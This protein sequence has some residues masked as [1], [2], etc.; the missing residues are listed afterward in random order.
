MPQPQ[1]CQIWA[2]S[3]TCTTAHSSS[4]S[5]THWARQEIKP[6]SSGILVRFISAELQWELR[7]SV[8]QIS[9]F[10]SYRFLYFHFTNE[11]TKVW[12]SW[13]LYPRPYNL[14]R[15]HLGSEP[16]WSVST[17]S[18]SYPLLSAVTQ[19]CVQH[20]LWWG[21]SATDSWEW[22]TSVGKV[23][24]CGSIDQCESVR[25]LAVV[26]ILVAMAVCTKIA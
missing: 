9:L 14:W 5:L 23:S 15:V 11:E 1:P 3:A 19:H 21:S 26:C 8:S 18:S 7:I 20:T 25:T 12:R 4:R 13:A 2:A 6:V 24:M 17:V 10:P 22:I 16:R